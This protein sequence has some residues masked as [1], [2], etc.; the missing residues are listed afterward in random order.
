MLFL[1]TKC[2]VKEASGDMWIRGQG[3]TYRQKNAKIHYYD[4]PGGR[5][6]IGLPYLS[7]VGL[8]AGDNVMAI[9]KSIAQ[10]TMD[11]ETYMNQSRNRPTVSSIMKRNLSLLLLGLGDA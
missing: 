9:T 10:S 1:L 8:V 3:E 7:N 4:T 11:W 5:R 6:L 2:A